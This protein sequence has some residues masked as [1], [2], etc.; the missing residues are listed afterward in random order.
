MAFEDNHIFADA[1]T[2][3]FCIQNPRLFLLKI[4]KAFTI[5]YCVNCLDSPRFWLFCTMCNV[6]NTIEWSMD[7][8]TPIRLIR[9]LRWF[10]NSALQK[11]E[12]RRMYGAVCQLKKFCIHN[13]HC[14]SFTTSEAF[15]TL[16]IETTLSFTTIAGILITP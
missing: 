8:E 5:Y 2:E 3:I 4:H 15:R 6:E 14:N 1:N 11:T 13:Q 12:P 7:F 9:K 16:P 10:K